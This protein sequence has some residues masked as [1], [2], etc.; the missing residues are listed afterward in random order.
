MG[1]HPDEAN[2][3]VLEDLLPDFITC[4]LLGVVVDTSIDFDRD[5]QL[6]AVEVEDEGANRV[7]PAELEA[8]APAIAQKRPEDGLSWG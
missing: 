4:M 1:R 7:L 8:E 5:F 6:F 3:E 2:R